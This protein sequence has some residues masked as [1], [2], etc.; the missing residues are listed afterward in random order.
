L[1]VGASYQGLGDLRHDVGAEG[2][3]HGE[4][5]RTDDGWRGGGG[6]WNYVAIRHSGVV[7]AAVGRPVR[8]LTGT[9]ARWLV[10]TILTATTAE[11]LASWLTACFKNL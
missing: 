10:R 6:C 1:G 7:G 3:Q 8:R 2:V 11:F 9:A 5:F 4:H